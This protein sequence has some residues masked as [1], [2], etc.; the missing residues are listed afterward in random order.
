MHFYSDHGTEF[1]G[2]DAVLAKH[3]DVLVRLSQ[4]G[5]KAFRAE[6]AI[7][8]LR[9]KMSLLTESAERLGRPLKSR[10]LTLE[11]AV[12]AINNT[13]SK[14]LAG[15][16]P[17]R[18]ARGDMQAASAVNDSRGLDWSLERRRMFRELASRSTDL[19]PGDAVRI[20]TTRLTENARGMRFDKGSQRPYFSERL[21]VVKRVLPPRPGDSSEKASYY[22]LRDWT[23]GKKTK[24]RYRR[25]EIL[26]V[27][28]A[29]DPPF[30]RGPTIAASTSLGKDQNTADAEAEK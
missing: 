20:R 14:V 7:R 21:Y 2:I 30:P 16:S 27:P 9:E 25:D 18:V 22:E 4:G 23:S 1:A 3:G 12:N 10:R 11:V 26:P 19:V 28:R 5:R 8:H 13:G 15:M 24:G 29:F 6:V 17:S